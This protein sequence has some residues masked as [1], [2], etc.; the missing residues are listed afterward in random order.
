MIT[1]ATT[2]LGIEEPLFVFSPFAEVVAAVSRAGGMGVLGCVGFEDPDE[3]DDALT[4]LD[5]NTDGRP[6]GVDLV[7]PADIPFELAD[8]D[9]H[10]LLPD[11]HKNFVTDTLV[12][13]GV[14]AA[15]DPGPGVVGW[16]HSVART[17]FDVALNHRIALVANA[18]G[19]PPED[20][21]RRAHAA[22][23]K[24]AA[25]A[26]SARHAERHVEAGVDIVVAQGTEAGGHTGEVSTMVLVPD[27]VR[28][29][30]RDAVVLAAGGIGTGRQVAAALAL[31]AAGAWMGTRWLATEEADPD[32]R[33]ASVQQ[34]LLD[35]G[36]GDTVRTRIYSGKPARILK[37]R[38]TAVWDAD[39]APAPLPMPLQNML[40]A[41]AHRALEQSGDPTVVPLPAGQ[42][43]GLIDKVLPCATLF[44]EILGE[45]RDAIN[46]LARAARA[47]VTDAERSESSVRGSREAGRA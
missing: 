23:I 21:I 31:G 46:E 13:L 19:S 26:G 27:V 24:V 42:V 44:E 43:V 29:V 22:E 3:L 20:L 8:L 36:A 35:A 9:V 40:V 45:A 38:W 15:V 11:Q 30:G 7:I 10:S 41:A 33:Y 32:R 25:L 5:R 39:D 1:G 37:N 47:T 2:L 4:W 28:T 14:R 18:L 6:Y 34:A 16:L 17:Q 12:Q